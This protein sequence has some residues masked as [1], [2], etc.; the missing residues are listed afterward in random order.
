MPT[1]SRTHLPIKQYIADSQVL[2][3]DGIEEDTDAALARLPAPALRGTFAKAYELLCRL[4]SEIGWDELLKTRSTVFVMEEEY[5]NQKAQ[6]VAE[7]MDGEPQVNGVEHE[8][9]VRDSLATAVDGKAADDDN[10]DNAST[11]GMVSPSRQSTSTEP[12]VDAKARA[13]TD[14]TTEPEEPVS[15]QAEALN[16]MKTTGFANGSGGVNK[17]TRA[18]ASEAD[19]AEDEYRKNHVK[20]D[21][22]ALNSKRLCERWLDNMFMCLYEVWLPAFQP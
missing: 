22:T 18:A 16:G 19:E 7:S 9:S 1:P 20:A 21:A 6:V 11:R 4:V 3:G 5:R 8:A 10:D 2:E 15:A 12:E 13:S 17:P 14:S